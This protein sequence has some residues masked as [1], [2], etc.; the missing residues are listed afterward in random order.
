VQSIGPLALALLVTLNIFLW[1]AQSSPIPILRGEQSDNAKNET[2]HGTDEPKGAVSADERI[3]DYTAVLDVLTAVLAIA[4]FLQLIALLRA[5]AT[6]RAASDNFRQA[7]RAHV[8][9]LRPEIKWV[10]DSN[11]QITKLKVWTNWKNSGTTPAKKMISL[12]AVTWV[13]T[14]NE[15]KFDDIDNIAAADPGFSRES[16]VLAPLMEIPSG[17]LTISRKELVSN[18]KGEGNQFFHGRATYYDIFPGTREH[19]SEFCFRISIEGPIEAPVVMGPDGMPQGIGL[20][21]GLHG[22]RN[23]YIDKGDDD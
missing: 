2:S 22:N 3:A 21:F 20:R 8:S 15:F 7:Q 6:A 5:D 19:I 23:R 4:A 12:T 11:R 1:A 16:L 13:P 9:N 10:V 17:D 14:G 18:A